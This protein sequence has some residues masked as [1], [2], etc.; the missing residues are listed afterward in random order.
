MKQ[1]SETQKIRGIVL[2]AVKAIMKAHLE[3]MKKHGLLYRGNVMDVTIDDKFMSMNFGFCDEFK[4]FISEQ[5][6]C[7]NL[8]DGA[9]KKIVVILDDDSGD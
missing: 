9:S 3:D 8:Q 1:D 4:E 5:I 7:G 2:E 6:R